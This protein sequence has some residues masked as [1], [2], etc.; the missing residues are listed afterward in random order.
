LATISTV[1]PS[2]AVGSLPLPA[3]EAPF[4]VDEAALA[5]VAGGEV[6]ELAPEDHVV[7]LGVALAVGRETHVRD[8]LARAGLPEFRGGD[9]ASDAGYLD[10]GVLS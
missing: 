8:V 2:G 1:C 3:L 4:N 5:E 10:D 9:E 7:E 6:S